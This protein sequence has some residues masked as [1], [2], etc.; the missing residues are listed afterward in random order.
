ME[1][2]IDIFELYRMAMDGSFSLASAVERFLGR[3]PELASDEKLDD[4]VKKV[5]LVLRELKKDSIF[6]FSNAIVTIIFVFWPSLWLKEL[7]EL[8]VVYG[9]LVNVFFWGLWVVQGH[10]LSV[11]EVVSSVAELFVNP[12]YTIPLIGCFR[13][14]ARS[15]VDRAVALLG[16]CNLTSDSDDTVAEPGHYV[17]DGVVYVVEHYERSGR[18]LNLH[19]LACLAFCRSLDLDHSLLG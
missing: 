14:I 2:Y 8:W 15:I 13:P 7:V 12:N 6:N 11:E 17:D 4:L 16:Q 10:M 19:E 18:G 5:F 3:C 9:F 1:I